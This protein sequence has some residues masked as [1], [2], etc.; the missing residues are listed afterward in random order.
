MNRDIDAREVRQRKIQFMSGTVLSAIAMG[1]AYLSAIASIS[2]FVIFLVSRIILAAVQSRI[3]ITEQVP[4][5]K[6]VAKQLI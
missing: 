5:T 3:R 1:V 4:G 6:Q 2:I